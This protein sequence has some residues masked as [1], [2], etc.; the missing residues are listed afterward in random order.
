MTR[1]CPSDDCMFEAAWLVAR[2]V[3]PMALLGTVS[4]DPK[5]MAKAHSRLGKQMADNVIP[6][7]LPRENTPL[8]HIGYA[9][10]PWV[11]QLLAS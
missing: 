7:V 4:N 9:A 5:E 10:E 11:I 2:G 1:E 3:R 8:A 6:F